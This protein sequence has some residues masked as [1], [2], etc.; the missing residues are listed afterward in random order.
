MTV[1]LRVEGPAFPSNLFPL[2]KCSLQNAPGR[3]TCLGRIQLLP[4][5][6]FVWEIEYWFP[7]RELRNKS[8]NHCSSL[9]HLYL[10]FLI[11]EL[12]ICRVMRSLPTRSQK[13]DH[14]PLQKVYFW[15]N[16]LSNG[17]AVKLN[18]VVPP[19]CSFPFHGFSYQ[20]SNVIW[21]IKWKIP[22]I[23]NLQVI[24]YAPFWVA[25]WNF[26]P[27]YFVRL[28]TSI[29]AVSSICCPLVT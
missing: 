27:L 26:M 24:N 1:V 19:I 23:N 29:I 5:V 28:G 7:G 21:N 12:F 16:T 15:T 17:R 13:T 2:G 14:Q 6:M 22:E 3:P 9:S 10:C 8:A 20:Q 25:W 4:G 11:L 18:T